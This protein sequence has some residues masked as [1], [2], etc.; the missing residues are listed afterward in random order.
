MNKH[1]AYV[2]NADW[3]FLSHRLPLARRVC[4]LGGHVTVMAPETGYGNDIRREGMEFIPVPVSRK[5]QNPVEDWE[6][7]RRLR[8]LYELVRPD[9]IHHLTIKPI[10]YGTLAAKASPHIPVVN[11]VTGL[12]Y[13]FQGT[14]ERKPL[15]MA[16]TTLYRRAFKHPR[17]KAIFQ[18]AED[19]E[20]FERRGLASPRQ[21]ALVR[22]SGVDVVEHAHLP[23]PSGPE[24]PVILM[25]ARMLRSKGVEVFLEAARLA[26]LNGTPGRWVLAGPVDSGNPDSMTADELERASRE[27][28]VEWI[29]MRTDMVEQI[30]R[31]AVVVLP[32]M[33]REGVP[34]VLL[35]AAA[36]GRPVI[37]TEA[38]GV[39]DIVID[40]FNGVRIRAGCPESLES[41]V[42]RL[43]WD[44]RLREQMGGNGRRLVESS[45]RSETIVEETLA[46]YRAMLEA[47][48]VRLEEKG[49][50]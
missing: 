16:V 43:A 9:L 13:V 48:G 26:R 30:R 39:R 46:I 35:E 17:V 24:E 10:I 23:E 5:G 22:S 41:A 12:G 32:T 40:G 27:D 47:P 2:L 44:A 18:N 38:P 11:G 31:S 29:G 20:E 1:I 25:A 36:T 8:R 28:N 15:E 6:L 37:G 33:Y 3:F 49:A 21:T 7:M 34:K 19:R 45:F 4:E 14:V 50:A 42:A